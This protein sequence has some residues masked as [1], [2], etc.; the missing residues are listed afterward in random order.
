MAKSLD[1][2]NRVS[3]FLHVCSAREGWGVPQVRQALWEGLESHSPRSHD[4]R[5]DKVLFDLLGYVPKVIGEE[6]KVGKYLKKED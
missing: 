6:Y 5:E 2:D 3:P 4:G 1:S